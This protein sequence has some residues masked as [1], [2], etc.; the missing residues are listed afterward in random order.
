LTPSWAL[1][2]PRLT[3]LDSTPCE[4]GVEATAVELDDR[5]SVEASDDAA[6]TR[7]GW[8]TSAFRRDEL[9]RR[10]LLSREPTALDFPVLRADGSVGRACARVPLV[11]PRDEP[12]WIEDPR[13]SGGMTFSVLVPFERIYRVSAAPTF[14]FRFGRWLGP[15]RVRAELGWGGASAQNP[16][17]NL[18]GYSYRAALVADALIAHAG[19]FGVGVAAAYDVMGISLTQNIARLSDEGE[20]F[21]GFLHGPRA[22]LLFALLPPV[23]IGPAFRAR[24]DTAS[25]TLEL[26]ATADF[27]RDRSGATPGLFVAIGIDGGR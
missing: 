8:H 10:G 7:D 27:A 24:P 3:D 26:F 15:T 1:G 23:P 5:T 16:N 22:G 17:P 25:A 12:E 21:Q 2:M 9:D 18:V 13:W 4:S 11:E 20:G 6:R 19:Q 14:A